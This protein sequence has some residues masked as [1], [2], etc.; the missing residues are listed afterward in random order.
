M[1]YLQSLMQDADLVHFVTTVYVCNL[2]TWGCLAIFY[3][4]C[5]HFRLF[6]DR[7]VRPVGNYPPPD[8]IKAA[9][10]QNLLGNLVLYPI[11]AVLIYKIYV[12]IH[13]SVPL[14]W[15]ALPLIP[16][17]I[18]F[19]MLV[20]D[21]MFYWTHRTLH[22]RRIYKYIHKQHHKF[23]DSIGL[24]AEYAHPVENLFGNVV[25]LWMGPM[26]LNASLPII[27]LW[28]VDSTAFCTL[29]MTLLWPAIKLT[30]CLVFCNALN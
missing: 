8:L 12:H 2:A 18:L 21:T 9:L 26:L 3:E 20:E 25:P 28:F 29:V 19:C 16:F 30:L 4:L 14:E 10:I 6:Q 5:H 15:P 27:C 13:G 17:Q 23:R 22:H 11:F 1:E 7:L 24:A